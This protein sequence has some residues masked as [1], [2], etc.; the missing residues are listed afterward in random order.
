MFSYYK[1]DVKKS[2]FRYEHLNWEI[3]QIPI[4]WIR[5]MMAVDIG[6]DKIFFESIN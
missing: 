2:D 5:L 6:F 4:N 1:R 3:G